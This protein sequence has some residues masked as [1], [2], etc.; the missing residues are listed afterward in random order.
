VDGWR[1]RVGEAVLQ[2]G[3]AGLRTRRLEALLEGDPASDPDPVLQA[4]EVDA[5]EIQALAQLVATLAPDMAGAEVFRDPDQLAAARALF[6]EAKTRSA[7]LTSPLPQYRWEEIAEGPAMRLPMMAGR[8]IIAEPGRRYSPL[9]VVGGSGTGKS[10]YLHALGNALAAAGVAPVACLGGTAFAAEVRGLTDP[11]ALDAWRRRYRWVGAFLLDDLH[12]L[13]DEPRAQE[14]LAAL[15]GE[16]QEGGRQMAFASARPL[17]ELVGIHPALLVRLESGLT[18]E[19]SPPDR[20]VR[21][22]VIKRLLANT[23]AAADAALIDYLAARPTDSIRSLQ[24][25]LQRLLGEAASQG[26]A[27]SPALAREV[28]E[29]MEL[30]GA[31]ASTRGAAARASG[32]LTPG[33]GVVR[34]AEKMVTSWP[35]VAD[36]LIVELR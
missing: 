27:L 20:E 18:V 32:I 2:W 10:H 7:S 14:E 13:A 35:S 36:R 19:L 4:F 22:A 17:H 15:M 34:S 9:I 5:L 30:G 8:D 31:R 12:L 11:E 26:V 25:T 23:P 29:E 6:H 24:S 16:L 21:L 33:R 28:L 1:R 3:G